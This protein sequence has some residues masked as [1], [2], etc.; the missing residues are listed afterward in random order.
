VDPSPGWYP[1]AQSPVAGWYPDPQ[2]PA[3]MRYWDGE[4]WTAS[5]APPL[6]GASY[7]THPV[8]A[9]TNGLAIASLVCSLVGFFACGVPA[10]LGVVFGH[11]ARGQIER[12]GGRQEGDGLALA[13]M[14]IGYVMIA[15]FALFWVFWLLVVVNSGP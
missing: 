14:I 3:Q 15:G 11:V 13:G 12:S 5:V 7:A 6:G 8:P 10:I 2:Q 9:Q 4:V 1:E